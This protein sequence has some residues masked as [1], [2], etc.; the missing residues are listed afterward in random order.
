ML[1]AKRW[2][3]MGAIVYIAGTPARS[4]IGGKRMT[5][6]EVK[7]FRDGRGWGM[8]VEYVEGQTLFG[9]SRPRL[10]EIIAELNY[11]VIVNGEKK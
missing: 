8:Y 2:R 6:K 10:S 11:R 9:C 7:I 1:T 5:I 3:L 4:V